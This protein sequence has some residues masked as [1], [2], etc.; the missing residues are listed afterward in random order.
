MKF[1]K[2]LELLRKRKG[3]SQ[4]DLAHAIGVSRQTIY[5]WEAGVNYPNILMLKK[6]ARILDVSTD[7]LLHG[8]DVNKL[9]KK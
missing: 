3:L 6:I 7:D 5:S 9:P 4:E 2:N 1:E 8:Y